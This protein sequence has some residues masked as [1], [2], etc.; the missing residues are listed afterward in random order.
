MARSLT[1]GAFFSDGIV[2]STNANPSF[3]YTSNGNYTAQLRIFDTLGNVGFASASVVVGNH[4]PTVQI[5]WPPNGGIFDWNKPFSF[6]GQASDI[7]RWLDDQWY[8]LL[9]IA[10]VGT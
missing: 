1:S 9:A 5:N 8:R 2:N 10:S 4:S 7:R 3:T 6:A